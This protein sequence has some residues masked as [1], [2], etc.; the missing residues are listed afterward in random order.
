MYSVEIT[1]ASLP[2]RQ[3][4]VNVEPILTFY[5]EMGVL[6]YKLYISVLLINT[7]ILGFNPVKV[8]TDVKMNLVK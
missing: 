6:I 4:M 7:F 2:T 3:Q 8:V 1:V 5:I